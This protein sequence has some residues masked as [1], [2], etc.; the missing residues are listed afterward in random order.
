MKKIIA[1][2]ALSLA[3]SYNAKAQE[4]SKTATIQSTSASSPKESNIKDVIYKDIEELNSQVKLNEN[5]K[6]DLTNIL[7]MRNEAVSNAKSE[8]E[9]KS[10]FERYTTKFIG[11]LT[12]EQQEMLK[13]NKELYVKLTVYT[14]E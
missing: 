12:P 3:F 1:I 11:G 4:V 9:K 8:D 6:N 13:R 10:L 7:F 5:L 2:M 14:K